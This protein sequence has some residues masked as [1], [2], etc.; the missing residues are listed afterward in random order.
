MSIL[1]KVHLWLVLLYWGTSAYAQ[2]PVLRFAEQLFTSGNYEG[3]ITEYKRFLFFNHKSDNA[4]YVYHRIGLAY[5][6]ERKWDESANALRKSIQIAVND[7]IRN[8]REI[9]LG[10]MLIASGN[11][12]AAE[13]QLLRVETFSPFQCLKRKAAFFRG[14]ASVYAF[15]WKDAKDAFQVY[16]EHSSTT[17]NPMIAKEVDS[18]LSEADVLNYK[19]PSLAKLFSTFIPGSGQIYAGD[20][21][22]GL[23]A[24]AIN[25]ASGYLLFEN[26]AKGNY[27]NAILSYLFLFQRFYLGNIMSI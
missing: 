13:F 19:S 22:N 8:E 16:F 27:G 15:K 18:L 20:W 7:S 10:V 9:A 12:S 17:E 4:S 14:I 2:D 26:L 23:N 11:Y 24:M 5:R 25:G 1:I 21:R 3:A 6:N